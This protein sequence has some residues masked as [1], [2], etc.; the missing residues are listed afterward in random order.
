MRNNNNNNSIIGDVE[1]NEQLMQLEQDDSIEDIVHFSWTQINNNND[2][3]YKDTDILIDTGSTFSV[4]KNPQM[5]LNIKES[6]RKMKAYTNGGRQDFTLVGDL[7]GFFRVWYNPKS[8]INTLVW[9]D[10]ANKYRII[11]DT[12]KGRFIT[13]HLSETRR[14]I[15]VEVESGLYLFRDRAYT[16]TNN[17]MSGYSYLM[18]TEANMKD[19]TKD[20]VKR[21]Q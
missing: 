12:A 17:K 14:M 15:F 8:M 7:P 10:I 19:F 5:I 4:L 9:A 13:D 1:T 6:E 11:S 21:A 18:L 20:E 2:N 16:L 3:K